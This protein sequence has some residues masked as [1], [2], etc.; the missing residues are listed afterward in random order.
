MAEKNTLENMVKNA[1]LN[2]ENSPKEP[3]PKPK[4]TLNSVVG[5]LGDLVNLGVGVAAPAA[6]YALTGNV[7][8]P[9]MSAAFAAASSNLNSKNVRNESLIG[10]IVGSIMHYFSLPLKSM[11][12]AAKSAYLTLTPF[13]TNAVYPPTDHLVKN[14][15]AKG[16]SEKLKNYWPNVKRTFK[17]SW[18]IAYFP[19]LFL[20]QSYVV[21]ALGIAF[22]IYRKF[23]VG[24]KK[25]DEKDVDKTPYS[26]AASNVIGK[27]ARNSVKG[28]SDAASAMGSSLNDLYK[29]APKAAAPAPAAHPA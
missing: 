16:I 19:S 17:T 7:G 29:S 26:A 22:Y 15:T 12:F 3:P 25:E 13:I 23:V 18:P 8:V 24:N 27:L 11:S 4:S 10:A 1:P 9:V 28:I 14:K 20:P 5:E 21:T 2:N 6:G